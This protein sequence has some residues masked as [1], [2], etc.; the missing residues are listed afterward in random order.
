MQDCTQRRAKF[1]HSWLSLLWFQGSW[2]QI[3]IKFVR[4]FIHNWFFLT[5]SYLKTKI[6]DQYFDEYLL[7]VPSLTFKM[8]SLVQLIFNPPPR[9]IFPPFFSLQIRFQ[10]M[11]A[12][13]RT[14]TFNP[15][16]TFIVIA[17]IVKFLPILWIDVATWSY[18]KSKVTFFVTGPSAWGRMSFSSQTCNRL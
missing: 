1:F 12:L 3:L 6:C 11:C 18:E 5:D 8:A 14:M 2:F 4:S 16:R 15:L 13:H 17:T 10:K 7:V 9:C